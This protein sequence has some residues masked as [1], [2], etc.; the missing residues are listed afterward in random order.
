MKKFRVPIFISVVAII[1]I[2]V[3]LFLQRN[4]EANQNNGDIVVDET[5]VYI[6]GLVG[7]VGRLNPVLSYYSETDAAINKLVYSS[8]FKQSSEGYPV[9]DLVESWGVSVDGLEYNFKLREGILWHDGEPLTTN[10]VIYTIQ[11]MMG[12]DSVAPEDIKTLWNS[13]EINQ[14]DEYSFKLT[15]PTPYAPFVDFLNFG[16]IPYHIYGSMSYA[17][18]MNQEQNFEPVGSGPYKFDSL[19]LEGGVIKGL[20]LV[21]N[22][23]YYLGEPHIKNFNLRLYDTETQLVDAYQGGEI[24]GFLATS[25]EIFDAAKD[26]INMQMYT[27]I[28]PVLNLAVFNLDNSDVLFLQDADIREALLMAVNREWIV[29]QILGNRAIVADSPIFPDVWGYV[30]DMVDHNYNPDEAIKILQE[31]EYTFADTN[32]TMRS[33]GD[34]SMEM[35]L[36]YPDDLSVYEEI[37]TFLHESW[38][39]LGVSVTLEAMDFNDMVNTKLSTRDFEAA[40]L[41]YDM[42]GYPDPDPYMFWHQTQAKTGQ[43]YSVW[44]NRLASE[45]LEQARVNTDT[46]T[47]RDLYERFQ[48]HFDYEVPAILLYYPTVSYNVSVNI[49]GVQIGSL[50]DLTNRFNYVNEWYFEDTE[51]LA[52]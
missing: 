18:M 7:N 19:Y 12:A 38:A 42:R 22:E 43:N 1:V 47:R 35:T 31:K 49:K 14:Y 25:G 9:G 11:T 32:A 2:G 48:T 51:V 17:D 50:Y 6:E 30:P 33:N 41:A 21:A 52:P 3:L 29:N 8:L 39:E 44:N 23:N 40:L 34:I 24:N 37:A 15:L 5:G 28:L 10:D 26:D 13:V 20:N 36:L 27:E 45:Y 46:D 4:N 16:I